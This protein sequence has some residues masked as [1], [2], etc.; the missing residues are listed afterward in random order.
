MNELKKSLYLE[1]ILT[2]HYLVHH[3]SSSCLHQKLSNIKSISKFYSLFFD[4]LIY[5]LWDLISSGSESE[6]LSSYEFEEIDEEEDEDKKD[7]EAAAF[8]FLI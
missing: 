3:I 2:F 6:S 7:E 4:G 5:F 8:C 1:I